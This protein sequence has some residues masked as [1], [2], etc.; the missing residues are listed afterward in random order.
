[1][2][3]GSFGDNSA[4]KSSR[5]RSITVYISNRRSF[6]VLAIFGNG[7]KIPGRIAMWGHQITASLGLKTRIIPGCGAVVLGTTSKNIADAP[8]VTTT[9]RTTPAST[10]V[11]ELCVWHS[12][13]DLIL[14]SPIALSLFSLLIF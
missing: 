2:A 8:L 9:S 6:R 10:S 4:W 13:R 3:V 1:M 14:F 7:V 12:A 11:F 5:R